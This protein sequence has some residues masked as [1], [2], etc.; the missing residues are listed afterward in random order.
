MIRLQLSG[1][2]GNQ[3][4]GYAA[5]RAVSI[6]AGAPLTIDLRFYDKQSTGT[7]KG[8][9][10][11]DFPVNASFKHYANATIRP[12]HPLRRGFEKLVLE[13][14]RDVCI[15]TDLVFNERVMRL[16]R[17]AVLVGYFQC[18]KYFENEWPLFAS[19]LDVASFVDRLW[20]T[21]RQAKG[22]PWCAVHVRRG[23]YVGDPR[24]EMRGPQNYYGPA[25]QLMAR[26]EPDTRFVVFSDDIAWCRRQPFLQGCDFYEGA[27]NRHPAVDLAT[28]AHASSNIIGNSSYSWWAAWLGQH[29][30]KA[31]VA[32]SIWVDGLCTAD[33]G[34]L[35][36][37][38]RIV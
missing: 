23:D 3:L 20:L 37:S 1:G 2:L 13:R 19:E 5:A 25:M 9:W 6:R 35:P 14:F 34:V 32:P 22:Q 15:D 31:I 17:N 33:L 11:T 21:M 28:M 30:G 36:P 4:F 29:P 16:G 26:E 10:L 38:W 7:S 8:V 18:Y 27:A 24:F 12:H